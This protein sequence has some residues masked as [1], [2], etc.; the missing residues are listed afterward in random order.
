VRPAR[1]WDQRK[2]RSSW[3]SLALMGQQPSR[4]ATP[5]RRWPRLPRSLGRRAARAGPR[6]PP[7]TPGRDATGAL[8][9]H[10]AAG[11]SPGC[12]PA[13]AAAWRCPRG[14]P[15]RTAWQRRQSTRRIAYSTEDQ[16][17]PE[18]D[19]VAAPFGELITIGRRL[20]TLPACMRPV[21]CAMI[22]LSCSNMAS[23]RLLVAWSKRR[24]E[25][26]SV[27]LVQARIELEQS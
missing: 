22:R 9:R 1:N 5:R 20:F 15:R 13:A 12:G 17:P 3:F 8:R 2:K 14:L 7:P 21:T 26:S 18:R 25:G 24:S 4:C 6:L 19:E 27:L 10:A 16:S 11:A 23:L